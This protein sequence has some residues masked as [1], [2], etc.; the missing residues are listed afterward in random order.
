MG[1]CQGSCNSVGGIADFRRDG[2][3]CVESNLG[4]TYA[5]DQSK[6]S[7]AEKDALI[8]ALFRQMTAAEARI[9]ALEARLDELIP[10]ALIDDSSI[11]EGGWYRAPGWPVAARQTK[12]HAD[13]C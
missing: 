3:G 9:A 10:A 2:H 12:T 7:L 5:P 8:L 1:G 6:L 13:R 11:N 4:V